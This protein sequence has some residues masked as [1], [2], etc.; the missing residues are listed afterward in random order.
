[1]RLIIIRFQAINTYFQLIVD[2]VLE[3]K[4]DLL[5]FAGDAVFI[6]WKAT[7]D[8]AL[9]IC[10][11]SAVNCAAKILSKCAD[12][13]VLSNGATANSSYLLTS[14]AAQVDTLNVH[15]GI[16]A[17]QMVGVHVGDHKSR[18][19]YILLGEP[20]SQATV[21]T[22][23]ASLGEVAISPHAHSILSRLCDFKGGA[24]FS[25][26]RSPTIV[27]TRDEF[28]FT[29]KKKLG[30]HVQRKIVNDISRGV[31]SHVEGLEVDALRKYRRMMSL[32][33][34]PV[35]VDNDL[36]AAHH[37]KSK[38]VKKIDRSE[39]ERHREEAEIRNVFTMFVNPKVK[40]QVTND[41][42]ANARLY[43]TL[44]DIMN[45]STREIE[46]FRGHLRQFIVDDKGRRI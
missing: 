11:E 42:I 24:A 26:G 30:T 32:Y 12:F 2:E 25:D 15:C 29:S 44:N 41:E 20:I 38:K 21:A 35:V 3:W 17:G 5:K 23:F 8:V 22:E 31:T 10:V 13:S 4:G 27:A 37:I 33:V 1:L 36:A 40:T 43:E 7:L 18:R 14:Q 28:K 34:H 6:E 9:E 45:L 46:R 39:Q 19:E 16:G